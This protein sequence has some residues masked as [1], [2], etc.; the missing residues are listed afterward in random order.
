MKIRWGYPRAGSI[1]AARTT[2]IR[3]SLA[4]IA[5][6]WPC[7]PALARKKP[8]R[9]QPGLKFWERMPERHPPFVQ[10]S[11]WMQV[12]KGLV[13]L[14]NLQ[15]PLARMRYPQASRRRAHMVPIPFP[16]GIITQNLFENSLLGKGRASLL[17]RHSRAGG[18]PSP[19]VSIGAGAVPKDRSGDGFP[20]ARE[21]RR[22]G[23]HPK[24]IHAPH[25]APESDADSGGDIASLRTQTSPRDCPS[26]R[27]I[28]RSHR[29]TVP[30]FNPAGSP[31]GCCPNSFPQRVRRRHRSR[32]RS[33][34][35]A[36][37]CGR[38]PRQ[39][40]ESRS[41]RSP[42]SPRHGRPRRWSA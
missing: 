2:P 9:C 21:R 3:P 6:H 15:L 18:K 36:K 12:R 33:G 8:G 29:E 31:S 5:H 26:Y 37:R 20:R 13:W 11:M 19:S 28:C 14:H 34:R 1:P 7:S 25:M 4:F 35:G 41:M 23:M 40:R 17:L 10:C 22:A 30:S 39:G 42:C 38:S 24:E 27:L 32:D 16:Y